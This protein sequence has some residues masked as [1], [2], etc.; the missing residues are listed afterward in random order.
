MGICRGWEILLRSMRSRG[1]G[2]G[3]DD[4]HAYGYEDVHG[5]VYVRVFDDG[6][7]PGLNTVQGKFAST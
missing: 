1:L 2:R 6:G 7:Q 4:A 5:Y 3:N